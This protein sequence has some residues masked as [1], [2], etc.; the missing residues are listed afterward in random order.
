MITVP[1]ICYRINRI[2][3]I[4]YR[5][6]AGGECFEL[7]IYHNKRLSLKVVNP[8]GM[9]F[10]LGRNAASLCNCLTKMHQ[11]TGTGFFA[12]RQRL[13]QYFISSQFFSHFFRQLNGRWQTRQVLTGR[14][15]L[16]VVFICPMWPGIFQRSKDA[17]F[18]F[19][20][21]FYQMYSGAYPVLD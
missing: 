2:N 13:L 5:L 16:F 4:Q 19:P 7:H 10:L 21:S 11:L 20:D 3:D 15:F 17:G 18:F 1:G 9:L 12:D 14:F 6:V 8:A